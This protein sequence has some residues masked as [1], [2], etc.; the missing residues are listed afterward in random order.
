MFDEAER[1]YIEHGV[2][3]YRTLVDAVFSDRSQVFIYV[4]QRQ[5]QVRLVL[6]MLLSR[7]KKGWRASSLSNYYTAIYE[8]LASDAAGEADVAEL[9]DL[10][11]KR[12]A[13]LD[14]LRFSPMDPQSRGYRLLLE[15]LRQAHF[16]A[17]EY[18]CF[19]NWFQRVDADWAAYL[20][21]REGAVRSTIKRMGKKFAAAGGRLQLICEGPELE[22]G[23]AAYEQVYRASWK[24]D[25]PYPNFVRGLIRMC[26]ERG[27]LR[28][29]VAW[30]AEQPIAAQIWIVSNGKAD[31]YKLAYHE[32]FK[33]YAPGTLLTAMLM[34]QAIDRDGIAEIDYL[35]G[36]DDY[37]RA[38][39]AERRERWGIVAYNPRTRHGLLGL[40]RESI[41]RR[42]KYML[43][44]LGFRKT[45]SLAKRAVPALPTQTPP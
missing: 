31:I 43:D 14:S 30:L 22:T 10:V 4:L 24:T 6:P 15:G 44:K 41:A 9:L 1:R 40:G 45:H 18:F 19:G 38:W 39:M 29:G 2:Y 33:S 35:I 26:A 37:K 23:I 32:D 13:P 11:R 42:V 3:W 16:F 28:L 17:Y 27:W 12:H 20:A 36:D 34:E 8:P 5:G 21:T 25:E 7:P